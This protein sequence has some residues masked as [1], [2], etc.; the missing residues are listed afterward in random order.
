[1]IHTPWDR[2]V[3]QYLSILLNIVFKVIIIIMIMIPM[4]MINICEIL[5]FYIIEIKCIIIIIY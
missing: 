2:K 1:M 3:L 4:I 5:I